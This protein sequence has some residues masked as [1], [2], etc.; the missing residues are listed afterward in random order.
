M[1]IV[2]EDVF[3]ESNYYILEIIQGNEIIEKEIDK[4]DVYLINDRKL[5]KT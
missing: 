4:A 3:Q 5:S 2:V 1:S